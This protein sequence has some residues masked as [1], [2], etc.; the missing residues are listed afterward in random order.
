MICVNRVSFHRGRNAAEV[1]FYARRFCPHL[2]FEEIGDCDR[3]ENCDDRYHDQQ[4]DQ[5][6]AA[7]AGE[8]RI[9]HSSQ[10]F[11]VQLETTSLTDSTRLRRS[12]TTCMV[13]CASARALLV[14]CSRISATW[15]GFAS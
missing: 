9:R 13:I 4:F 3:R 7:A 12:R 1:G 11:P 10:M 5:G 8:L 6:E 2:G 15:D 14:P